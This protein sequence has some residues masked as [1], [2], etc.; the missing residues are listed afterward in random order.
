MSNN[1]GSVVA[2][3]FK[4]SDYLTTR[5]FTV[6]HKIV[7]GLI[8]ADL[9]LQLSRST[10]EMNTMNARG[11]TPLSWPVLAAMSMLPG[12]FCITAQ[13]TTWQTCVNMHRSTTH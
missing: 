11:R 2:S 7:L 5:A 4:G 13:S 8:I 10:A 9:D 6:I 1:E 12:Y 3:L